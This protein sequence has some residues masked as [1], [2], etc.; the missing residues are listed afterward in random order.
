[1][2]RLLT[3]ADMVAAKARLQP[4]KTAARDSRRSLSF[5]QWDQRAGRLAN[6]LLGLGLSKGD[7]VAL[8]AYNCLEWMELYVALAR[9]PVYS[10]TL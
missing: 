9:N 4:N 5:R 2:S 6:A 7:R 3:V 10:P 8:L 1:M